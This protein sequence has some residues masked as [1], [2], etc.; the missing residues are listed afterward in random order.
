MMLIARL[1]CVAANAGLG[2]ALLFCGGCGVDYVATP[3]SDARGASVAHPTVEGPVSGGL[4]QPFIASTTYDPNDVG[5]SEAE[6]FISG[7]ATSY[8]AN[9]PLLADGQWTV[10]EADHAAYKTRVVVYRPQDARRF[11]GTVIVE[12]LNVS[13][14]LDAAAGW[15]TGHTQMVR[16]G[17]AWIGVSAQYA[18]VEGG[19]SVLGLLTADLKTVD[20]ERYGSLLHPGDSFSYDMFS[21]VAQA[22]RRPEGVHLLGDLDVKAVIASGESQSAFRMVTYI[23]GIHP[24]AD[25]FD[26]FLVHSRGGN[27][28]AVAPLSEPPQA[29]II[30]P[31]KLRLRTDL[32]VPVLT[33]QTET[34]LT[35][36]GSAAAR[37]PDTDRLR[38][39]EVAGTSHADTYTAGGGATDRGYSPEYAKIVLT[40][41]PVIG[42]ACRAPIN[43]GP[44]HF[45]LDAAVS[46]L[47]RWVRDGVAPA[48]APRL[49]VEAEGEAMARLKRDQYGNALGG[50][51][52][53]YVDVPIARFSGDGKGSVLCLLFG[54]TTPFDAERL[55]QLYPTHDAYVSQFNAA[56]DRALAAGFLTPADAQLLKANAATETIGGLS[57]P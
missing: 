35:F 31:A 41:M 51:R 4:G 7:V 30:V 52:S 18:G 48:Q 14:G 21:Q 40:T 16:E 11:N 23:N 43:S 1:R 37:Q 27:G 2:L 32:N 36:L 29:D 38:L 57:A 56:T 19:P 25:I 34:D 50:I 9:G 47:N 5:Y 54:T 20:P 15:L 26:G 12:W 3:A 6:Y 10:T 28:F 39:W 46:A 44:H 8:T 45:V 42:F 24:R 17:F 55:A 22:V 33:F 53:P 13:G 49:E